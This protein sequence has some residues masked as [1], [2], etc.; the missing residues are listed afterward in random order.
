MLRTKSNDFMNKIFINHVHV[1]VFHVIEATCANLRIS[2]IYQLFLF[3]YLSV[4]LPFGFSEFL[5]EIASYSCDGLFYKQ[6]QTFFCLICLILWYQSMSHSI[7]NSLTL[8]H[9]HITFIPHKYDNTVI[10][11]M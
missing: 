6:I 7:S 2:I 3:V 8:T 11:Y 4:C 10:I 5:R 9:M 1:Y